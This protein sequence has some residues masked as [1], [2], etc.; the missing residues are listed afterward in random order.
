MRAPFLVRPGR[1]KAIATSGMTVHSELGGFDGP[2]RTVL[3]ADVKPEY[4]LILQGWKPS[5][6]IRNRRGSPR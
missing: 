5:F 4:E 2:V 6:W 3:E 1:G